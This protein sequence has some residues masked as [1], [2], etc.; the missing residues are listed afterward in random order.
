MILFDVAPPNLGDI[1]NH[2]WYE[3]KKEVNQ[4]SRAYQLLI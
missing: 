4:I 2:R 1:T 3:P